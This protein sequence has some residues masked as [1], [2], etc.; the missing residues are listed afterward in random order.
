MRALTWLDPGIPLEPI[1]LNVLEHRLGVAFPQGYR[2][3]ALKHDGASNPDE[4]AFAFSSAADRTRVGNFGGLLSL[5]AE[6]P[7]N[8]SELLLECLES[9]GDRLP[10][11]VVPIISTGNGDYI[12]LDYRDRKSVP[13]IAYFDHELSNPISFVAD[14]FEQFLDMLQVP[15]DL[16]E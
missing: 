8:G 3:L 15:D 11:D 2:D 12:C 13:A 14:S 5:C 1:A 7:E 4:S 6:R 10:R 9:L 16:F